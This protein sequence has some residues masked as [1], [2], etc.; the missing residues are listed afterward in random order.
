MQRE[1]LF[2]LMTLSF[3]GGCDGDGAS[4]S[5]REVTA[6]LYDSSRDCLGPFQVVGSIDADAACRPAPAYA[7]DSAGRCFWFRDRCLPD[8]FVFVSDDDNRCPPS[9]TTLPDDC[10]LALALLTRAVSWTSDK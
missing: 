1:A 10:E 7:I 4:E 2:T 5:R 6:R 3:A 8:G 9:S